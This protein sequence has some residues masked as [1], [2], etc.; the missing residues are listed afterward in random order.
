MHCTEQEGKRA[1]Q[2]TANRAGQ[3]WMAHRANLLQG[4]PQEV[5]KK[6]PYGDHEDAL[7]RAAHQRPQRGARV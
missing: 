2:C 1:G 4:L 3:Y 7:R 6:K 5:Y